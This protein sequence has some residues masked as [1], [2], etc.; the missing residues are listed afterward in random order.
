MMDHPLDEIYHKHKDPIERRI[1]KNRDAT[2]SLYG[3]ED[4]ETSDEVDDIM[5]KMLK[6][7][8]KERNESA[9]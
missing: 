5:D 6:Q 1:R 3:P 9:P 7:N 4:I 2:Q 8:R